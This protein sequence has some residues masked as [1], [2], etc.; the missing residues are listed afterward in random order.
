MYLL[1]NVSINGGG[2]LGSLV[3]GTLCAVIASGRGRNPVGW[4]F[5]GA[6]LA[7]IGFILVL[8][9]PDLNEERRRK[10]REHSAGA[11]NR[12][13]KE[14]LRKDRMVTDSRLSL[15]ERRL[16]THDRALGVDTGH[17]ADPQL[18]GGAAGVLMPPDPVGAPWYIADGDRPL[19]LSWVE[20]RERFTGGRV[21][22]TTLVWTEGMAE[23][24]PMSNVEGLT[25]AL[26][27]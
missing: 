25:E 17:P 13:L 21:G 23:W 11:E 14:Q 5:I 2:L 15:V 6:I 10:A 20:L 19:L 9:L 26:R 1:T 24:A 12:L 27:V 4:F 18:P 7:C 16:Q 3:F 8:C 22:P